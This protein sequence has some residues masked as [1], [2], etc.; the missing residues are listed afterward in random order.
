MVLV[1]W[2]SAVR[3]VYG[4]VLFDVC[5]AYSWI[6]M[7]KGPG[8]FNKERALALCIGACRHL[9]DGEWASGTWVEST[10]HMSR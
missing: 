4:T 6:V 5:A 1:F 10:Y 2:R 3:G 8:F 7:D 9:G